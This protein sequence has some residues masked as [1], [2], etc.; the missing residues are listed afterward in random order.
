[1][2]DLMSD[3]LVLVD[4]ITGDA[5]YRTKMI[6]Q[7]LRNA[8]RVAGEMVAL[9]EEARRAKEVTAHYADAGNARAARANKSR[10]TLIHKA[11]CEGARVLAE[12]LGLAMKT[13]LGD[14]RIDETTAQTG[15]DQDERNLISAITTGLER[16]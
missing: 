6:A 11:R 7:A 12:Q 9:D 8:R 13:A 3:L 2:N 15:L 1:M 14:L 4:E 16:W 10:E 5:G